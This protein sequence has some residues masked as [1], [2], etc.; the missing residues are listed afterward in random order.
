[1][2]DTTVDDIQFLGDSVWAID[3]RMSG[4]SHITAAYLIGGQRPCLVETGTA[5][6]APTVTTALRALGIDADDLASIVVTH[7]HLDHAGG[8]GDLA[9]AFPSAQVYASEAGVEHLVDPTRLLSSARRVFGR[10]LDE[11]FGLLLPVPATQVVP[12]S[13]NFRI[14]L[15]GGRHLQVLEAPGHA[16]HHV[17]LLDSACGDL[18]VGDAAGVYL[19]ETGDLRPA[20]PPPDFD[21][22]QSLN[23]LDR[24]GRAQPQRL[25]F[26]HY[27]PVEAAAQTLQRSAEELRAWVHD[28]RTALSSWGDDGKTPDATTLEMAHVVELMHRRAEERYRYTS[29]A[30]MLEKV[31]HLNSTLANTSGVARWLTR[32]APTL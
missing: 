15:G 18:Y 27:G 17:G 26:S 10:V 21:L 3:T 14:D 25:L 4:Y 23:T 20:T 12:L 31:E 2:D 28:A 22:E 1:M 5:M 19:P 7:V 24:F 13:A 32:T 6:S 8:A 16:R 29:D 30:A 11:V 9:R